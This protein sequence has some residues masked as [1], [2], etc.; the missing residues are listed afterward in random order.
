VGNNKQLLVRTSAIWGLERVIGYTSKVINRT[1]EICSLLKRWHF[2]STGLYLFFFLQLV[3][4]LIFFYKYSPPPR[5]HG[6]I[7]FASMA[8]PSSELDCADCALCRDS[9]PSSEACWAMPARPLPLLPRI[10]ALPLAEAVPPPGDIV[11]LVPVLLRWNRLG[12]SANYRIQEKRTYIRV[13]CVHRK[14]KK[15]SNAVAQQAQCQRSSQ[16]QFTSQY[17]PVR[18]SSE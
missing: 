10:L 5:L 8:R 18:S 11:P 1:Q 16:V 17:L 15:H 14:Q 7:A 12:D 2:A 13:M 6:M 3:L 4:G 9:S